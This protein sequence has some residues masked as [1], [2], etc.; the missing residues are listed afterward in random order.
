[1]DK[2]IPWLAIGAG[3]LTVAASIYEGILLRRKAKLWEGREDGR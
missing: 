3:I 1:M 2:L